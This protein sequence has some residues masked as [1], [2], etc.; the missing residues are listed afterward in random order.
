MRMAVVLSSLAL[1]LSGCASTINVPA[2]GTDFS[3]SGC[4]PLLN[5]VSSQST[6]P[7]YQTP[8]IQLRRPLTP[9]SW[10]H[11]KKVVLTLPGA[12]LDESRY[13]YLKATCYSHVFQFP[14]F[15]ELLVGPDGQSLEVRSQSML[16]LYDF[17]VNRHRV[18]ELRAR[19]RAAGLAKG[20]RPA[21]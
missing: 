7:L 13:G 20:G 8:P 12:S 4:P 15:L 1:L 5:C 14:D 11:V 17:S 16:G 18:Q 3:L 21:Q 6:V 19:L 10:G 9:S 2:S